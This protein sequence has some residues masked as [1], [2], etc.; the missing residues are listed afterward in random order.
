MGFPFP[1]LT[2]HKNG[3]LI[4][5]I[6]QLNYYAL[7]SNKNRELKI[8]E[9]EARGAQENLSNSRAKGLLRFSLNNKLDSLEV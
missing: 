6:F 7:F 2:I 5:L 3:D 8:E 9:I 4:H 1:V